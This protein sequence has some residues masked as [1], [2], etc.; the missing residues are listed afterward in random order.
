MLLAVDAVT[1]AV[2]VTVLIKYGVV[3][4]VAALTP[5]TRIPVPADV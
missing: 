5:L 2:G 1:V 3:A 4:V